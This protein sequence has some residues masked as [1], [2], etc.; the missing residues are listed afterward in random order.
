M[1]FKKG[2][3]YLE[4]VSVI[5]PVY[6]VEKYLR[7]CVDSVINQTYKN[8]EI[9]LVDDGSPDNCPAIC[10]EYAANDSRI[11]VIHKKNG[12]LS[13]ARNAALDVM[14]GKYVT[15][16]DSDDY[17]SKDAIQ[18][19]YDVLKEY[20]TDI[21]LGN[22]QSV[23]ENGN[24][25]SN[26]SFSD[27]EK[28]LCGD[29]IYLTL[30]RPNAPSKLYKANV[31]DD[32]RFPLG[33]LYEDVFTWH[34]IL[35]KVNRIALTGKVSYYYLVRSGSIMHS[36]YDIR[37]TDIIFAIKERYEW[38]DSIGQQ[39]LANDARMFIYTRTAVAFAHLDFSIPEHKRKLEEIKAIYDDCYKILIKEKVGLKQKIRLWML[40]R[41]PSL[42]TEL[43]GK[44]MP[45]ALG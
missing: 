9:W 42:H 20:N 17:I 2:D 11:K 14:T 18:T 19:M 33:R 25:T 6:K 1:V 38:L 35:A 24:I 39:K 37:F 26:C 4:T 43:F 21:S 41:F 15:F 27:D 8:L 30:N 5:I 10:D 28:V 34:K 13:D 40:Y 36:E 22:M 45:I 12:G 23:S 44:K 31:F 3:D 7:K 32:I 29:D 16:V